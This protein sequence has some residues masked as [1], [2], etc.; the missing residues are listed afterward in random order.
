MGSIADHVTLREITADTVRA[1]TRLAV[2]DYQTRF[3][4]SN[5]W[6]LGQA[7]FSPEAWYRAIYLAE[8]PVGFVMLSDQSLLD[9]GREALAVNHAPRGQAVPPRPAAWLE[10]WAPCATPSAPTLPSILR[11]AAPRH[12]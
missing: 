3:V 1:V 7:L 5:A 6:S 12:P 2:T 9:L 8:E 10:H 11:T 4:A